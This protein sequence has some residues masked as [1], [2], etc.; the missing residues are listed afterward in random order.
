M[1]QD[2][3]S[4]PAAAGAKPLPIRTVRRVLE[5]HGEGALALLEDPALYDAVKMVGSAKARNASGD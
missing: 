3:A 4:S 2:C 1:L 5:Q